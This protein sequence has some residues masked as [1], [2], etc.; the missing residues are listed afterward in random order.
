[1]FKHTMK[2]LL[3]LLT[4]AVIS[5]CA[6]TRPVDKPALEMPVLTH[7]EPAHELSKWWLRFED[8]A[9][10]QMIERALSHNTDLR[11]AVARVDAATAELR[12]ARS[13]FSP[14]V[15]AGLSGSRSRSS[16]RV[17]SQ[18][19]A[20]QI[21][22]HF[23]GGIDI[24]YEVDLWGR[25]RSANDAAIARLQASREAANGLRSALAAQVAQ[26]YFSLLALDQSIALARRTQGTR[27][28]AVTVLRKAVD[29]GLK[30]DLD[31]RQG[32]AERQVVA[33]QLPR[34]EAARARTERALA[35]LTGQ[36]PRAISES[37]GL[38]A[39][40]P[41]SLLPAP[42][43]I[44]GGLPSDLLQRRPD[45][46]E[47]EARLA[48]AQAQVSEARARY[49]PSIVLTGNVGS[50][51]AEL[52]DLFSGPSLVWRLAG[53]LTQPIFGLRRIEA[54]V[55][56][57][58]ARQREAEAAYVG[59]VQSAFKEV[60][61]ALGKLRAANDTLAPVNARVQALTE[62]LRIATARYQAGSTPFIE[63]LDAERNLLSARSEEI[64]IR[65]ERLSA[66]VNVFRALG[67]GWGDGAKP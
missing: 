57:A 4:A 24:A 7:P 38:V 19:G 67:G 49:Y 23:E 44:P 46:R 64:A 65:E 41:A 52:S 15:N 30:S 53:G 55:D 61:D 66:T 43:P 20:P 14:S 50:A 2:P 56:V 40:S 16:E 10:T 42:P 27:D 32:E 29:A 25:V 54:Q 34:L 58:S 8:M 5:A 26:S 18:P 9:L 45:I 11:A 1:M 37:A 22:N 21:N 6:S 60:Y 12:I 33:A 48:A 35:L 28:E 36:S 39:V 3:Y 63:A 51:S 62:A 31:L 13:E 47:S 59:T 17:N